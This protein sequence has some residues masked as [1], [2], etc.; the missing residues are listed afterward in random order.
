MEFM[1]V[2]SKFVFSRVFATVKAK[3]SW[4]S[5]NMVILVT[6]KFPVHRKIFT[7]TSVMINLPLL[8]PSWCRYGDGHWIRVGSVPLCPLFG[9]YVKLALCHRLWSGYFNIII[10]SNKGLIKWPILHL[11]FCNL[12]WGTRA[13]CPCA[14]FLA[15]IKNLVFLTDYNQGTLIL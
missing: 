15:T 5:I 3:H 7:N 14:L 4:V 9:Y 2:V 8:W 1:T 13:H 12:F 6:I 11:K 10:L